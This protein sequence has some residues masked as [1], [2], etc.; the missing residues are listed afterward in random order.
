MSTKTPV[1]CPQCLQN[2]CYLSSMSTKTPVIYPQCLQKLLL[3]V[4]NLY[5]NLCYLPSMSTKTRVCYLPPVPIQTLVICPLRTKIHEEVSYITCF[6]DSYTTPVLTLIL[7]LKY[8]Q[9]TGNQFNEWK[10]LHT[11]Y[12][13][14]VYI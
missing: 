12:T 4:L 5:K 14:V 8:L 9:Y 6:S 13:Y 11:M 7:Y 10:T 1:I 3:S 2:S